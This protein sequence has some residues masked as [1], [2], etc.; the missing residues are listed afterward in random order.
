MVSVLLYAGF[1]LS[2]I[3]NKYMAP[4]EISTFSRCRDLIYFVAQK[5]KKKGKKEPNTRSKTHEMFK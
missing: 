3:K 2:V 1:M 4:W 5:K